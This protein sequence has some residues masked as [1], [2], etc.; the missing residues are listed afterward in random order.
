MVSAAPQITELKTFAAFYALNGT[1]RRVYFEAQDDE[2]ARALCAQWGAGLEG[3]ATR[4]ETKTEP[5]PAAYDEKTARKLLGGISQATLYRWLAV[6][7]LD[8]VADTRRLLITRSSIER[9]NLV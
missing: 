3:P 4:P 1:I 8:R 6:G 7:K 5:L 2:E 9:Q